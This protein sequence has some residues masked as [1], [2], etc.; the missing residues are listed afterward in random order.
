MVWKGNV[1]KIDAW[2]VDTTQ[3]ATER[4]WCMSSDAEG[5][6]ASFW[7]EYESPIQRCQS[8]PNGQYRIRNWKE[9][10]AALKQRRAGKLVK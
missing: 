6:R 2:I 8:A 1:N 9:Y 5:R 7:V 10:A 4:P 3:A